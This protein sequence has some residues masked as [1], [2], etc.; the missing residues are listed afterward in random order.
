[1]AAEIRETAGDLSA[2]PAPEATHLG[3][4]WQAISDRP[5][6]YDLFQA[7]RIVDAAHPDYP[8]LGKAPRPLFEPVRV[9]QLPSVIFAPST[10]A[11]VNPAYQGIP[12]RLRILS[13]GLFGPNGPMPLSLTEYV[14]ERETQ[15]GD[16]T[17]SAFAD[18]FHHRFTLLFYRAWA[19]AQAT[20]SLDK[21]GEDRFSTYIASLLGYGLPAQHHRGAVADHA[22]WHQAGHLVRPT[23][24][25]EGLARILADFFQTTASIIEY[26]GQWL[27]LAPEQFTR[28]GLRG[29]GGQLGVGA[30][31]GQSIWDR[32]HHFTVRLGP[33]SLTDYEALLPG[34]SRMLQLLDWVRTYIG[35]EFA[36]DAN[37]VL[38][39]DAVPR[40]RLGGSQR[41]GWTSWLGQRPAV[42]DA[43]DLVVDVERLAAEQV[44]A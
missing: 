39:A 6:A 32:Q 34:G 12:P 29:P 27:T 11:A 35:R 38:R 20:V 28:L 10:I 19:D 41:L 30:V 22:R 40:A 31:A 16:Y 8:R 36:W 26:T 42:R 24:N 33:M 17:L 1:M 23:R 5:F 4:F 14:H 21:N 2:Q 44:A 9:G 37:L 15:H 43:E 25:P 3:R 13:F 7:L 18:L